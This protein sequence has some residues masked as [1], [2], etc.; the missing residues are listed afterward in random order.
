[1]T[2]NYI[3]H[4]PCVAQPSH[5]SR[6]CSYGYFDTETFATLTYKHRVMMTWIWALE[7][8]DH[9]CTKPHVIPVGVL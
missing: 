4:D 5:Q 6:L 7:G 2:S 3:G 9:Y 8:P 1:M